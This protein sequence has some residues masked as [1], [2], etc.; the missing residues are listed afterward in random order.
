MPVHAGLILAAGASSRMGQPKALLE[1]PS[2]IPLI[3]QQVALLGKAGLDPV[4]TVTGAHPLSLPDVSTVQN[5]DWKDGRFTSIKTGLSALP[6][7]DGC[8]VI[9]V[10]CAGVDPVTLEA[11]ITEGTSTMQPV[12]AFYDSQPGHLLWI[13]GDTAERLCALDTRELNVRE[14]L[15][16]FTRKLEVDDPAVL[17]NFNTPAEWEQFLQAQQSPL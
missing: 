2:G 7:I 3:R 9:P 14:L 10:D 4:L 5:P 11:V 1:L 13:P 6:E 17:N 8:L 16:P 12:R 15:A